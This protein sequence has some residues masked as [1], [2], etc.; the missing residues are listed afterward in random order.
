MLNFTPAYLVLNVFYLSKHLSVPGF[1]YDG[2]AALHPVFQ[3]ACYAFV[4]YCIYGHVYTEQMT[5][6][7]GYRFWAGN[8]PQAWVFISKRG[9][10]KIEAKCP[11]QWANGPPGAMMAG[12]GGPM[13][14]FQ[15]FGMFQ[16]AQLP[17]RI[18]PM[19]AHKALKGAAE[20][21]GEEM[22]KSI[23]EFIDQGGFT[24]FGP[25]F[26]GWLAG[27]H[28]N[29]G[30]R[31]RFALTELH[32]VC[33]FAAGELTMIEGHS[34]PIFAQLTGAR[35]RWTIVDGAKGEIESG[36]TTVSEALAIT[37]PSLLAD[38]ETRDGKFA[39]LARACRFRG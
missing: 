25:F 21:R 17:H 9:M 4:P 30:L 7:N 1:D 15:W 26:V 11:K 33:N 20:M 22:P 35:S 24:C 13:W 34:F 28:V 18:L 14:T 8:W 31:S 5:Y 23:S 19:V 32:K 39:L 36:Y 27:Y 38:Y 10:E 37:R 6:M 12:L 29:D 16:T 3:W 2:F